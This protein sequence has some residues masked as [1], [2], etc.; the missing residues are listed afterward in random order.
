MTNDTIVP[1]PAVVAP[2]ATT[3]PDDLGIDRAFLMQMARVPFIAGAL[4]V[5]AWLS[6][7]LWSGLASPDSPLRN[8]GPLV[9]VCAGMVLAAIVDGVAFKVPNWLTLSLVLSG[10]V[11]GLLHTLNVPLDSGQGGIGSALLGTLVGFG[12]LFPM[13]AIGGMGQ[14]DVKMQMGFGAWVGAFFPSR[15]AA[16]IV[17]WAFCLGAI[18]G[19]L[20]GLV[21]MAIRRQFHK[22]ARNF[23]EILTDLRVMVTIGPGAAAERANQRRKEWVRLPYGV[24]LCVGFVG[25]LWYL[26]LTGSSVLFVG[27]G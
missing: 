2:A 6:H 13:L 26:Y 10:W 22:N 12:L 17:L 14:G 18:I 4:V 3:A 16:W 23:G 7:H 5:L 21:M 9:V 27:N 11:L 1:Q 24:P 20:F 15:E 25:Y 19:G 8:L